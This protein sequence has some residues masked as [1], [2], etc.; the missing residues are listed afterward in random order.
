MCSRGF[1]VVPYRLLYSSNVSVGLDLGRSVTRSYRVGENPVTGGAVAIRFAI[2]AEN[3]EVP[4]TWVG[5]L[6]GL[7]THHD[8][9]IDTTA[10]SCRVTGP[11]S[12]TGSPSKNSRT[13]ASTRTTSSTITISGRGRPDRP[14]L[15]TAGTLD[16]RRSVGRAGASPSRYL[17]GPF[18]LAPGGGDNLLHLG[19]SIRSTCPISVLS[20]ETD[21]RCF[22]WMV[23]VANYDELP[24]P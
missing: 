10:S 4:A 13:S 20:L 9:W 21:R 15:L 19:I 5:D 17:I 11:Q 6:P 2:T 16:G 22:I 24:G 7:Q 1:R 3:D 8:Y 18:R 23:G 14:R 12:G